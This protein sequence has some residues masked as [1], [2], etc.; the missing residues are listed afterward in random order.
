[1]NL[2]TDERAQATID[3]LVPGQGPLA[4]ELLG[5]NERLEVMVIVARDT[6]RGILEALG[7]QFLNLGGFHSTVCGL[8]FRGRE[9]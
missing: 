5:N 4:L 6:D 9:V 3:Q 2:V 8:H 1:M 7:D